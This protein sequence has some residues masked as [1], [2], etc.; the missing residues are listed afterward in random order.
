MGDLTA[1]EETAER[2]IAL[3][4]ERGHLLHLPDA[5]RVKGMILRQQ[6]RWDEAKAAFDEA[7]S[8]ARSMPYPYAE[9]RALYEQGWMYKQQGLYKQAQTAF[10][11]A[12]AIFQR[13]GA[14]KDAEWSEQELKTLE[15]QV[16]PAR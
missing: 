10:A 11:E 7:I 2:A 6:E 5:L 1:A 13:L 4:Q 14:Q 3:I 15:Q 9:S 8:T 16:E 12:L